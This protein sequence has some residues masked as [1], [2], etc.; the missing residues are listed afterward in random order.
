MIIEEEKLEEY[1]KDFIQ[2]LEST[3]CKACDESKLRALAMK[4]GA[5]T[6]SFK[7]GEAN[8]AELA[9]NIHNA[10][11]TH[12]MIKQTYTMINMWKTALRNYKIAIIAAGAALLSALAAWIA[13]LT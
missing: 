13:V 1:T 10:L 6:W 8:D 4:V 5:S 12:T 9:Y 7:L 11:Q 3:S 2:I